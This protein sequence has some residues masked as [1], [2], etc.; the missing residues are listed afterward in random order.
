MF[1]K[2]ETSKK[3]ATYS[4]VVVCLVKVFLLSFACTHRLSQG[5]A[6]VPPAPPPNSLAHHLQHIGNAAVDK[7][8]SLFIT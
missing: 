7:K 2:T 6:C 8:K 1:V 4:D 3:T 5:T